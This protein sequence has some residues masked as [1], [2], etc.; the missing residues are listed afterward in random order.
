MNTFKLFKNV[1]TIILV[2]LLVINI[3]M[4]VG[5]KKKEKHYEDIN[6]QNEV[7]KNEN[8]ILK[9]KQKNFSNTAREQ[10]YQDLTNQ[11]KLFINLAYVI[12]QDG[13]KQ[14]KNEAKNVMS[15]DLIDRFYPA[16]TFYQK[17]VQTSVK[18]VKLYIEEF[19]REDD[20]VRIIAE[21]NHE[22]KYINT[23]QIDKSKIYVEITFEHDENKWIAT[24]IRDIYSDT[25]K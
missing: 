2:T 25:K 12:K 22:M 17:Q 10:Y 5:N 3:V 20:E 13:Y 11:A 14:R 1:A 4:F 6:S 9:D 19:K 8:E 21:L 16:D 23:G 18:D 15:E 24:K 7:L